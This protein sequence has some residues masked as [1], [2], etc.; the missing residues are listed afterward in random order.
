MKVQLFLKRQLDFWGGIF[1]LVLFAIPFLIIAILI[2]LDSR[3][4]VL[5]MQDRVGRGGKIFKMLKFRTMI[6]RAWEKGRGI[7]LEKDDWRITRVGK[8]L[9]RFRI[10]EFPQ[11]LHV[12]KG[13]M[14][15]VGPRP[16]LPSQVEKYTAEEQRRLLVKP[17]MA[18]LDMIKGGNLISWKERITLDIW[19]IDNWNLWLDL[20]IFFGTI[21]VIIFKKE[22]YGKS[23]VIEDYK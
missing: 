6:D 11:F 23:G 17:G 20:K 9:R 5:F 22:Q 3:G 14:S 15:F 21:F 18:S 1:A 7:E 2:K 4:P 19:Y 13:E 10:D 12:V 16:G 8:F